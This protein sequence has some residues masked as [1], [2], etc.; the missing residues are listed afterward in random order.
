MFLFISFFFF[1]WIDISHFN[2]EQCLLLSDIVRYQHINILP[3]KKI[4][5]K[6]KYSCGCQLIICKHA[7][8]L[9]KNNSNELAR[10]DYRAAVID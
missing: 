7:N 8:E 5:I 4:M 10:M 1:F 3:L 9:H 2:F 6:N